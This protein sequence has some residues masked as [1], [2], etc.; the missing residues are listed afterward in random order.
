M[1][2]ALALKL[3]SCRL[4]LGACAPDG[5]TRKDDFDMKEGPFSG[6]GGGGAGDRK[7]GFDMKD[8]P[9]SG[10]GGAGGC[11]RK[12]GAPKKDGALAEG[13]G[14]GGGAGVRKDCA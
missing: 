9:F 13:P 1:A 11:S 8:G 6:G 7:D 12:E 14:G 2:G 5:P 4:H 3:G 10:G